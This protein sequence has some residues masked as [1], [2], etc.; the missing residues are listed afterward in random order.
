MEN[1]ASQV[2]CGRC[3]AAVRVEVPCRGVEKWICD[4][5]GRVEV[6]VQTLAPPPAADGEAEVSLR[7]EWSG[8]TPRASDVRALR[9]LVP[10]LAPESELLES[11]AD[12]R[13]CSLPPSRREDAVELLQRATELGLRVKGF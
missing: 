5:C 8:P 10:D 7:V 3:G 9:Q 6:A 12:A 13:E 4:A 2:T 1:A 11:L